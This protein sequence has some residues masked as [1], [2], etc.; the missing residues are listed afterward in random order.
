MTGKW[1]DIKDKIPEKRR[2]ILDAYIR[3]EL[4]RMEREDA[5]KEYGVPVKMNAELAY[6]VATV[7]AVSL[8]AIT[9]TLAMYVCTYT[10][11]KVACSLIAS[12][13]RCGVVLVK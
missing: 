10:A 13:E 2:T 3:G 11:G 1:K 12:P 9:L 7:A 4:E 8:V 5:M 6:K